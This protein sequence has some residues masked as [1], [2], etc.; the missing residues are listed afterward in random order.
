[1]AR[2]AMMEVVWILLI[3]TACLTALLLCCACCAVK[4]FAPENT[5]GPVWEVNSKGERW[6]PAE[7]RKPRDSRGWIWAEINPETGRELGLSSGQWVRLESPAGHF[8][9]RL[10]FF[11][12]AQPGV[13]NVPYGLHTVVEGW[14]K[15]H[16]SNPLRAIGNKRDPA[17]GLPDWYSTRIHVI[18]I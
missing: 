7:N 18:P 16:G 4:R 9:A 5:R 12:G 11:T 10:R 13:V 6:V 17:T 3:V 8:H 2:A 15:T 14:G 1:M